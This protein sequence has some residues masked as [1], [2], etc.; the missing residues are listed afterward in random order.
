MLVLQQMRKSFI[1]YC[2]FVTSCCVPL[3]SFLLLHSV[4]LETQDGENKNYY[5]PLSPNHVQFLFHI[6]F[7]QGATH[8]APS[9]D[10]KLVRTTRVRRQ[11]PSASS[12]NQTLREQPVIFNHVY[13]INVPLE[14]L[15]SVDLDASAPPA[16]GKSEVFWLIIWAHCSHLICRPGGTFCSHRHTYMLYLEEDIFFLF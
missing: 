8:A 13:N 14:S 6:V 11:A 16:P 15:C 2:L 1:L 4:I 7:L 3:G 9:G 12:A 5:K 10:N